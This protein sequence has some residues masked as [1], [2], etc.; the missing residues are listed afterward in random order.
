M[1]S[2][3]FAYADSLFKTVPSHIFPK[4]SFISETLLSD[5]QE[6]L[7]YST[8]PATLQ[9]QISRETKHV[10]SAPQRQN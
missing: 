9:I 8:Q 1:G 7:A 3:R 5:Q 6:K 2:F 4:S 10:F